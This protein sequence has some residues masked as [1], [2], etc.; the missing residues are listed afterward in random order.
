MIVLHQEYQSGWPLSTIWLYPPLPCEALYLFRD[1][2]NYRIGLIL[3]Q[4]G[5]MSAQRQYRRVRTQGSVQSI[6]S[7][8]GLLTKAH[9]S[10][11]SGVVRSPYQSVRHCQIHLQLRQVSPEITCKMVSAPVTDPDQYTIMRASTTFTRV[12]S[13]ILRY[14]TTMRCASE[15]WA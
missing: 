6:P 2:D 1:A 14:I 9:V 15:P 3:H 7:V 10:C 11:E 4:Q 12:F 8:P 13:A 5:Y